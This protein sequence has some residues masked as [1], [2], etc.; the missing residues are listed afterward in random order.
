MTTINSQED[1]LRALAENPQWKEAVRAQLLGEDLLQLP[2]QFEA[3][4]ERMDAFIEEQRQ[5]NARLDV[6]VERMDTF[7]EEQRR[8]SEE[9]KRRN[10]WLDGILEEQRR[11]SEELKRR[12]EWLDSILEEQRRINDRHDRRFI[13]LSND[14]AQAKAGHARFITAYH[15]GAIVFGMQM[16]LNLGIV[17]VRDVTR[18]EL[19]LMAHKAAG[20]DI[21]TND[22]RSFSRAD[23]VIE[24]AD[25]NG[26]VC[27]VAVEASFTAS[28]RDVTRAQR[29]AKMLTGFT[30]RPA[31]AVV[32]SVRNDLHVET[33][34]AAGNVWWYEID[35]RDMEV[36]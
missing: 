36:E 17:Y 8:T 32:S 34:I 12:N 14:V 31:Y 28:L 2:A 21:A 3:F 9:L 1:F 29:N 24:A 30:G 35:E 25:E 13:T 33:E 11:T 20:G 15:G 6:F 7:V 22:L 19:A 16:D 26:R 18:N 23:L 27:Y 4:V 5:R 10:E